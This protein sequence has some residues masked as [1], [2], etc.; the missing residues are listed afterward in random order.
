MDTNTN[1]CSLYVS[2]IDFLRTPENMESYVQEKKYRHIA[3][4]Y[5]KSFLNHFI[6]LM[7][8]HQKL[9]KIAHNKKQVENIFNDMITEIIRGS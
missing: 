1:H 6:E 5:Y 2:C 4:L 3:S 8:G 9:W 7:I